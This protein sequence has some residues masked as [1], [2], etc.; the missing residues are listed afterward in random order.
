ME[1]DSVFILLVEDLQL[2]LRR[3]SKQA[4]AEPERVFD[5]LFE[6]LPTIDKA[7]KSNPILAPEQHPCKGEMEGRVVS[8]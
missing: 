8:V 2:L 1:A 7:S 4:N 6:F 3:G 5:L